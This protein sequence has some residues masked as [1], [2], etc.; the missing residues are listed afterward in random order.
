MK[1]KM[2]KRTLTRMKEEIMRTDPALHKG[3]LD[4]LNKKVEKRL[5]EQKRLRKISKK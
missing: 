5:K 4:K 3:L 2:E 1:S